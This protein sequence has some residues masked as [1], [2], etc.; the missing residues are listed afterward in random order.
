MVDFLKRIDDEMLIHYARDWSKGVKFAIPVFE[1]IKQEQFD[2]LFELAKIDT[3]GKTE[4][5]DGKTG[6]KMR[7]RVNVG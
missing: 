1:G 5:Y 2:K 3:D 7:E 6:E 4:L